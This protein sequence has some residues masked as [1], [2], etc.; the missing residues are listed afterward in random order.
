MSRS[1][2][3]HIKKTRPT[4][5]EFTRQL[6]RETNGFGIER[7]EG[8]PRTDDMKYH[9]FKTLK[10]ADKFIWAQS[11]TAPEKG[12][13]YHKFRLDIFYKPRFHKRDYPDGVRT[14]RLDVN[15]N[16]P[17]DVI[18]RALYQYDVIDL[19]YLRQAH[20]ELFKNAK[21]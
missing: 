12:H 1:K 14:L 10:D 13:G 5:E 3:N 19:D 20:P 8:N 7:W 2:K 6:K 9:K 16:A 15:K 11:F 4:F 18:E 17:I 21:G